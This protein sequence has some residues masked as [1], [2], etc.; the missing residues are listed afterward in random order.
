MSKP[1][2]NECKC[3]R[4]TCGCATTTAER[5]SCGEQCRCQRTCRCG[6]GC[7]CGARK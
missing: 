4:T 1:N 6:D 3:E 7:A 2:E 5:C